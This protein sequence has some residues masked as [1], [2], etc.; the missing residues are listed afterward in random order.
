MA[1][2]YKIEI[3]FRPES[4]RPL[5]IPE[6]IS[7]KQNTLIEWNIIGG[8]DFYLWDRYYR[9]GLVFMLYFDNKSPF[10]WQKESL[11]I[12]GGPRFPLFNYNQPMKLAEGLAENKGDFKYGVK[13]SEIGKDEPI[14]DEDPYINVY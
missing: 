7:V 8:D 9:T 13:V 4:N 5:F 12:I 10:S 3:E 2:V 11:R 1:E 6:K 14:F